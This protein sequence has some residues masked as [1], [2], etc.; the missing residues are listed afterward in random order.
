MSGLNLVDTSGW[1]EYG[2]GT[3]QG[4][5]FAPAIEDTKNLVVSVISIYEV[6]K[7]VLREKGEKAALETVGDMLSGQIVEIDVSLVLEAARHKLPMADSIIYA[8]AQRLNATLW[9]QDRDFET[10]SGVKF[11]PKSTQP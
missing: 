11:F 2:A 8:S 10:L 6:F 4:S 9:T 1:L 5:L 7:K 3:E